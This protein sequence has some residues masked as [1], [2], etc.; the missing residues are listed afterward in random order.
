MTKTAKQIIDEIIGIEKGYVNNPKDRGRA[1]RWGVTEAVARAHGYMGDMRNL[2]RETAFNILMQSYYIDPRFDQ[3]EA[4]VSGLGAKLADCGV[5]MGP[6]VPAKFLQRLLN[7]LNREQRD[8]PDLI[9]DGMIG[10]ITINALRRLVAKRGV[11][12]ARTAL[13]RGVNCLQGAE[14]LRQTEANEEK[15]EFFLGWILNRID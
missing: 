14:Y 3:V 10:S 6:S 9:A 15:E 12:V 7:A 5:N 2:P 13:L 8:Y 1:T 4:V 11:D